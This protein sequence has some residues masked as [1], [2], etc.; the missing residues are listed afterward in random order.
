MGNFPIRGRRLIRLVMA[1]VFLGGLALGVSG[2]AASKGNGARIEA[3][4]SGEGIASPW[5]TYD[6]LGGG[7]VNIGSD[8]TG[9]GGADTTGNLFTFAFNAVRDEDG[10]VS[11]SLR[12]KDVDLDVVVRGEIHL[13]EPHPSRGPPSGFRGTSFKMEGATTEAVTIDGI[14]FPAGSTI[15]NSPTFDGGQ[16]KSSADMVCFEIFD[17]NGQKQFQWSAFVS[18]GNMQISSHHG[19]NDDHD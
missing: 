13:L 16:K 19:G 1:T 15:R 3:Y 4:G 7:T 8:L 6:V 9:S 11:G 12:W 10:N 14:V 17:E 5:V 2:L 18:G